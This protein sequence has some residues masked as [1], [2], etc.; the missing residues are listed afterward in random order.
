MSEEVVAQ[1][2]QAVM[3]G[4]APIVQA[5]QRSTE[6]RAAGEQALL[7]FEREKHQQMMERADEQRKLQESELAI[8]AAAQLS[9][10][11][12]KGTFHLKLAYFTLKKNFPQLVEMEEEI[13][14]AAVPDRPG[15]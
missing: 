15:A 11:A 5:Y 2:Q 1:M 10:A 7:E 8:K 12:Q 4:S 3:A 9:E 14:A 6:E 13:F